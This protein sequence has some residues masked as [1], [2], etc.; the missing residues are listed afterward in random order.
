MKNIIIILC[1]LVSVQCKAQ[2]DTCNLKDLKRYNSVENIGFFILGGGGMFG[3][4]THKMQGNTF[5]W[6]YPIITLGGVYITL[7]GLKQRKC[8]KI[9]KLK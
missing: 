9:L 1:F 8:R 4:F 3:Y 5:K 6:T 2:K 7:G